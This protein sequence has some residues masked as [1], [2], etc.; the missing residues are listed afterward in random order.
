VT[1][2]EAGSLRDLAVSLGVGAD[3]LIDAHQMYLRPLAVA[4]WDDGVITDAEYPDLGD[5]ARLL[6][7]PATAVD[8]ELTAARGMA[9]QATVPVNGRELHGGQGDRA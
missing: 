5:V 4:A 3:A 2:T 1:A 7:F 8:I 6:G 9:Q